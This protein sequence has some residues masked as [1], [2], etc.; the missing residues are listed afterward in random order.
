MPLPQVCV[1]YL[2]QPGPDGERVLLGRKKLGLGEGN[3]V[4]P[5]GKIEPG[6]T[7]ELAIRR[8]VMEEVSLLPGRVELMGDLTYEFPFRPAWSQRSWVF[9][10]R[11]W[12]GEPRESNEL[13]PEWYPVADMPTAR[14]W[15]DAQY[16]VRDALAGRFVRATFRFGADLR[17]VSASDHPAF[18]PGSAGNTRL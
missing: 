11:D 7:P 13:S 3:L 14:M 10:C 12:Q 6:E 4:G 8:E 1:C 15:D 17:T 16:W 2:L 9:L 5:G 18:A